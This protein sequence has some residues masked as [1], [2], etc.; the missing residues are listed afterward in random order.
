MISF[1]EGETELLMSSHK[2]ILGNMNIAG[3]QYKKHA[4]NLNNPQNNFSAKYLPGKVDMMP[5]QMQS[6]INNT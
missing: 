1:L 3:I 5:D 6:Y 4:G 2:K